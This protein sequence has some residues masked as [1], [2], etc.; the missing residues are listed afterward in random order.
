VEW[1]GKERKQRAP[2][3]VLALAAQNLAVASTSSTLIGHVNN[4]DGD[5]TPH[6]DGKKVRKA[7]ELCVRCH[8]RTHACALPVCRIHR[9]ASSTTLCPSAQSNIRPASSFRDCLLLLPPPLAS[10]CSCLQSIH[11]VCYS[12]ANN[13]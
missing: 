4:G 11:L 13:I 9:R 5:V 2:A 8:A 12:D 1:N 10:S 3:P 6:T 7:L